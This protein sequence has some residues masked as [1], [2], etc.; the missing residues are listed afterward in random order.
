MKEIIKALNEK[1]QILQTRIEIAKEQ[2]QTN[3]ATIGKLFA[4]AKKDKEVVRQFKK[5]INQQG[6][7]II[8]LQKENDSLF[9]N[10]C[11]NETTILLQK[12]VLKQTIKS[13]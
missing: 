10:S 5:I 13:L 1:L 2:E 11:S 6:K 7:Q 8:D 3:S 4:A 12:E 9:S